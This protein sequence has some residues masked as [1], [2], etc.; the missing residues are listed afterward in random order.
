FTEDNI[1]QIPALR[2][3]INLGY[4]YLSS[5]EAL[6]LREDRESNVLLTGILRERLM[7]INDIKIGS[8]KTKFEP[9]NI[10]KAIQKLQEVP[11]AEGLV[12]ACNQI[13]NLLV[14]GHALEQS[15]G[16]DKKSYTIQYIDWENPTNNHF[17]V[18][19]EFSVMRTGRK[20][21]Y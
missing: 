2:L 15:I 21:T 7:H 13:Y 17:H 5:H 4:Q 6:E 9:A 18:V 12:H 10:D 16:G 14:F 19:E 1:S 20:D 8:K 3:L 11:L